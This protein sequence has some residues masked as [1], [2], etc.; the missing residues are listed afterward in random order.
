MS[1]DSFYE[2]S[3]MKSNINKERLYKD[4]MDLQIYNSS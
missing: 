3:L 2:T 1:L 4:V